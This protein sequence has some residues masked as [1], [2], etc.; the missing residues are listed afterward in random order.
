M[1]GPVYLL[2]CKEKLND[3]ETV[4][5]KRK[6]L[7][8]DDED[9]INSSSVD[10]IAYISKQDPDASPKSNEDEE[11]ESD[12]N[13]KNNKKKVRVEIVSKLATEN[14]HFHRI[15]PLNV[16]EKY[17][18]VLGT[19]KR[20]RLRCKLCHEKT[21]FFCAK[22]TNGD[23]I[24]ALCSPL[25]VPLCNCFYEHV[26]PVE[27]KSTKESHSLNPAPFFSPVCAE[28]LDD[29]RVAEILEKPVT[30]NNYHKTSR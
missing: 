28:I 1:E 21:S 22:C 4:N 2:Y 15:L 16:L 24:F 25:K 27:Y 3:I 5:G 30:A 7:I 23:E 17:H 6:T 14:E 11:V 10:E 12:R 19:N 26:T 13:S 8:N 20:A 18:Q 9:S 29:P